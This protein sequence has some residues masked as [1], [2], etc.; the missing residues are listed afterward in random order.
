VEEL[1]ELQS[2]VISAAQAR[3]HMSRKAV[4]HRVSS[5]RWQRP[6]RLVFVTHSGPI[7]SDAARWI[8]VLATGDRAVLGGVT[9]LQSAGLCGYETAAIHVLL[10]ARH[11]VA[12]PPD[13]VIVHRTG[14]LARDDVLLNARPPRTKVAR[15]IVDAAQW[16]PDDYTARAVIAAAFQQRLVSADGIDE[17][18]SRLIRARRRRGVGSCQDR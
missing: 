7:G 11:R 14:V 10:P 12:Q 4:R 16:A 3:R 2:G 9:A 6:H 1:L 15:S 17:V 18:L 8:A 5:G 13:G